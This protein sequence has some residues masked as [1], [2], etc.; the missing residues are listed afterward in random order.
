M[1]CLHFDRVADLHLCEIAEA[2]LAIQ[3]NT[4]SMEGESMEASFLVYRS[5][6]L[7]ISRAFTAIEYRRS[8]NR[9]LTLY[10]LRLATA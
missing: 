6:Y 1:I 8:S 10:S 7:L 3:I 4:A 2:S 9:L 5:L